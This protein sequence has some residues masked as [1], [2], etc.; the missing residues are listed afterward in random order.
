MSILSPS[1]HKVQGTSQ[2]MG[3][4]EFKSRRKVET[5]HGP[6]PSGYDMAVAVMNTQLLKAPAEA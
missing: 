3:Q 6:L 1:S 4:K 2:K 5:C